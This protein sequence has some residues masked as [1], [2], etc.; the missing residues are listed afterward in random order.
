VQSYKHE[1]PTRELLTIDGKKWNMESSIGKTT[2]I[3]F[4]AR[5]C[6]YCLREIPNIKTFYEKYKNDKNLTIVSYPRESPLNINRLKEFIK[7]KNITYPTL[8]EP[9]LKKSEKSFFDEF[10]IFGVPSIW[11]VDK[12]G[13][14]VAG[15]LRNIYVILAVY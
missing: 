11:V 5:D 8:I 1:A 15:N 14:I 2:I 6:S 9:N 3:I 7:D 12:N 13:Y 4:W 10:K